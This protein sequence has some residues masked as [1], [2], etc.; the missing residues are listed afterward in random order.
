MAGK[1]TLLLYAA[2]AA[3]LIL[4]GKKKRRK[5]ATPPTPTPEEEEEHISWRSSRLEHSEDGKERLPFDE[6]CQAFADKLNYDKHNIY[7]TGMFHSEV[8]GGNT[9]ARSI[10]M[11][12]LK[13]QAPDCP[14][15]DPGA[16]TELMADIQEQLLAAVQR[17]AEK[18]SVT[19]T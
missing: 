17:Y 16:Y 9:S 8:Q 2:G 1:G 7:I 19:L 10:V 11:E 4:G 15:D 12:M 14:W 6:E 18:E 5:K 3:A 13:D